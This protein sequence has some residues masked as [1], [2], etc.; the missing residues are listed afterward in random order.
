MTQDRTRAIVEAAE[1]LLRVAQVRVQRDAD[2]TGWI[3]HQAIE[4]DDFYSVVEEALL[5]LACAVA[6]PAEPEPPASMRSDLQFLA[7]YRDRVAEREGIDFLDSDDERLRMERA[8]AWI[9]W[10]APAA[11]EFSEWVRSE[12]AEWVRKVNER[13][14]GLREGP[15]TGP[16]EGTMTAY[17]PTAPA[18]TRT[19]PREPGCYLTFCRKDAAPRPFLSWLTEGGSWAV[20]ETESVGMEDVANWQWFPIRIEEPPA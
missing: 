20:A 3:A 13:K 12:R 2:G 7:T 11:A 15:L 4:V 10:L 14:A 18:W 8:E 6:L 1:R 16:H 9:R 19:P 17:F 5:D